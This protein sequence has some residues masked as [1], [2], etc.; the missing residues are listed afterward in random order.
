M[1]YSR[2]PELGYTTDTLGL[3]IHHHTTKGTANHPHTTRTTKGTHPK[4]PTHPAH[5]QP[6]LRPHQVQPRHLRARHL[7][8]TIHEQRARRRSGAQG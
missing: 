7:R 5:A 6:H 2:D 1:S 8:P 4:H 3:P